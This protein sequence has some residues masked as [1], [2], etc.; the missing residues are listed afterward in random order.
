MSHKAQISAKPSRPGEEVRLPCRVRDGEVSNVRVVDV[1]S[2][3]GLCVIHFVRRWLGMLGV[4]FIIMTGSGGRGRGV[5][6]TRM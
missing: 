5:G 4:C 6:P 2:V 1:L 3:G